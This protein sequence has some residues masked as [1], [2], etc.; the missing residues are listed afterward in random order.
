MLFPV[1]LNLYNSLTLFPGSKKNYKGK[2]PSPSQPGFPNNTLPHY[3]FFPLYRFPVFVHI[4][5]YTFI[6]VYVPVN[7]YFEQTWN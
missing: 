1:Q 4:C 2:I 5:T 6:N 7:A 3:S